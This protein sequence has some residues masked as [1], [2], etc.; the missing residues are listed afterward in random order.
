[1]PNNIKIFACRVLHNALL[2]MENLEQ[3]K[4]T[5]NGWWC[6]Q[7]GLQIETLSHDLWVLRIK[8]ERLRLSR[9]ALCIIFSE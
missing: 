6:P 3:R 5:K 4:G 1:M 7:C 9:I 8:I 2:T